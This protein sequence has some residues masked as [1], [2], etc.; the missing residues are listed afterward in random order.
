VTKIYLFIY[1]FY[2][3]FEFKALQLTEGVLMVKWIKHRPFISMIR[4]SNSGL[5]I[6]IF[7]QDFII[8]A[9]LAS[10]GP[11]SGESTFHYHQLKITDLL[12][13]LAFIMRRLYV[14][15]NEFV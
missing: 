2:L 4:G 15:L 9:T 14:S 13:F 12:N 7:L 3:F 6:R 8:S 5:V 11:L 10:S 1:Y